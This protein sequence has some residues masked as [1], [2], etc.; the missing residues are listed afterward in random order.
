MNDIIRVRKI[1]H[2]ELT[3]YYVSKDGKIFN[4][5]FIEKN[6]NNNNFVNLEWF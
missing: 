5:K 1:K 3:N 2:P 4:S 6:K